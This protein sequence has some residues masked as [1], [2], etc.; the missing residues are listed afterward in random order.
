MTTGERIKGAVL[1]K[2]NTL[3]WVMKL[4]TSEYITLTEYKRLKL[5]WL[6]DMFKLHRRNQ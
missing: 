1:H 2:H 6:S 3:G 5:S 4:A